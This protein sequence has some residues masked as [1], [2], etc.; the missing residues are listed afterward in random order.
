MGSDIIVE[1]MFEMPPRFLLVAQQM[2]RDA[3]HLLADHSVDH[4]G[5]MLGK[6]AEPS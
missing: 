6:R 4:I 3:D 5:P 1:R 2:L